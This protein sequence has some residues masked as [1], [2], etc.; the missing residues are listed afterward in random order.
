MKIRLEERKEEHVRIYFEKTKDPQIR[1][2]IPQ[3]C[4]TVEEALEAWKEQQ[5]G[6]TGSFG[7]TVY[8]DDT[9]VGDVWCYGIQKEEV[10]HAMVSY[11]IFEKKYWGKGIATEALKLFLQEIA[12][13]FQAETVGAFTYAG[14]QGSV[15]VLE[16]NG[17]V[18]LEKFTEDGVESF[19][20]EKRPEQKSRQNMSGDGK[21]DA[22]N[23][24]KGC[25]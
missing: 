16:K 7:C 23:K 18:Q 21:A 5:A 12:G 2:M 15:R 22:E 1:R 13:R 8:A 20:Y 17:F 3:S 19:Y 14:N 25:V 4:R 6:L 11:C 9:Y 24:Q 10:P